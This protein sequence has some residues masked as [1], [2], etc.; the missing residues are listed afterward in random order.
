[1]VATFA[2]EV[3]EV[4]NQSEMAFREL[5]ANWYRKGDA[6]GGAREGRGGGGEKTLSLQ[7]S[8]NDTYV[9]YFWREVTLFFFC[10]RRKLC[11]N[12]FPH[13]FLLL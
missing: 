9:T 13:T 8:G 7:R 1:M 6:L 3:T 4:I 5:R 12:F 11:M 2:T 10:Q